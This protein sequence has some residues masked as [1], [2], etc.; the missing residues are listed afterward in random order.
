[1]SDRYE[2]ASIPGRPIG[3]LNGL[4][5][6]WTQETSPRLFFMGE[7][8]QVRLMFPA[9]GTWCQLLKVNGESALVAE[10]KPELDVHIRHVIDTLID[11]RV[12]HP[13]LMQ[14]TLLDQGAE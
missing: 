10:Y 3:T 14:L 7:M 9:S 13:E 2:V 12:Q 8:D 6:G 1:V 5:I 11:L 4:I